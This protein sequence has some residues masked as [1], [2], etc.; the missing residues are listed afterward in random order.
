MKERTGE[1]ESYEKQAEVIKAIAHPVR[2]RIVEILS[3]GE[4]CVCHLTALLGQR[5]PYVSQQLTVLRGA[6]LVHDHRDG[7]MVYYRLADERVYEVVRTTRLLLQV[8]GEDVEFASVDTSPVE[9][10]SCPRCEKA[11]SMGS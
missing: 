2:L 1:L 10:C 9:G 7:V 3:R 11:R 6:G 8:M 5:Q 4:A